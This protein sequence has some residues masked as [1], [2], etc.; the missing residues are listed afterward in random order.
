MTRKATYHRNGLSR[1]AFVDQS[2]PEQR[3][4]GA[5]VGDGRGLGDDGWGKATCGDDG[6]HVSAELGD[7]APDDPVDLPGEAVQETRL[8]SLHRRLADH[9]PW[10]RDLHL[11]QSRRPSGQRIDGDL[12]PW[13]ERPTE[14]LPVQPDDV[15]VRGRPEVDDNAGSAVQGVRSQRV[16]DPVGTDLLR[17]VIEQRYAGAGAGLHDDDLDVLVPPLEDLTQLAEDGRH[18]GADSDARETRLV[19][20]QAAQ[21]EH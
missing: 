17:V 2:E 8:Q 15:E 6:C 13:G 20:E 10:A 19:A 16:D 1:T 3:E 18:A 11:D 5:M 12:D 21:G 4:V 7:D 9:R 14:E